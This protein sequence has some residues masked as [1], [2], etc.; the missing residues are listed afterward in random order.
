[1][2]I[3][4]VGG[5]TMVGAFEVVGIRGCVP[6]RGEDLRALLTDLARHRGATLLLVES[7]L[8]AGLPDELLDE[9]RRRGCLV[10]GVPGPGDPLPDAAP[11]LRRVHAI[12]GGAL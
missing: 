10:Q 2:S 12:V 9:F 4:A 8:V 5:P 3:Y 7:N 11:L 6:A 1:M